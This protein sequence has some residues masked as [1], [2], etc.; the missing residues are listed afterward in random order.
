M[1][2]PQPHQTSAPAAPPLQRLLSWAVRVGLTRK[3]AFLLVALSVLAGVLT[4]L[5]ITGAE[6]PDPQTLVWL[7]LANLVLLLA[8]ATVIARE[9]VRLWLQRRRG[10]AGARLHVQLVV[11]FA[12]LAGAPAAIMAVATVLFFN[13]GVQAWFADPVRDAL[14]QSLAVGLLGDTRLLPRSRGGQRREDVLEGC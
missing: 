3:F 4:Y 1:A 11:L 5:A 9:I 13:L 7:L 6:G 10:E 12:A 2:K 8:L 14:G